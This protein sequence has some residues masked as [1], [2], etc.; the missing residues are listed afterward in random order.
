M[1][2]KVIVSKISSDPPSV[3]GSMLALHGEV[4]NVW[5]HHRRDIPSVKF[6]GGPRGFDYL[7]RK[8]WL[9]FDLSPE[10]VSEFKARRI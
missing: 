1:L 4:I 3:V 6:Q 10:E 7:W 5:Q 8:E 2:A 9:D